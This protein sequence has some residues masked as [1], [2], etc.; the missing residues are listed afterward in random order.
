[1]YVS[2]LIRCQKENHWC[3]MHSIYKK[4]NNKLRKVLQKLCIPCF[5]HLICIRL[6]FVSVLKRLTGFPENCHVLELCSSDG[7][8]IVITILN[9]Y[10]CKNYLLSSKKK[11]S[12]FWYKKKTKQ[13]INRP[14]YWMFF[15]GVP[16]QLLFAWSGMV[17]RRLPRCGFI[18]VFKT[19][20]LQHSL[21]DN[22]RYKAFSSMKC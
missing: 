21:L 20:M 8:I 2:S 3:G 18:F 17:H 7:N 4:H 11:I 12:R 19:S 13:N 6:I 16:P 22:K 14:Q 10:E 9:T 1:M 15:L 5:S